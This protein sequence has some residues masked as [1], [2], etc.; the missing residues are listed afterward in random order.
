MAAA[1]LNTRVISGHRSAAPALASVSF[2]PDRKNGENDKGRVNPSP[3]SFSRRIGAA[4]PSEPGRRAPLLPFATCENSA[5]PL[6]DAGRIIDQG[7]NARLANPYLT[8]ARTSEFG[9][10][11]STPRPAQ[12]LQKGEGV[13]SSSGPSIYCILGTDYSLVSVFVASWH[14]GQFLP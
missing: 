5:G 14:P 6:H 4:R 1:T 2:S 9:A 11:R 3:A 12:R 8:A 13:F 10:S 7:T